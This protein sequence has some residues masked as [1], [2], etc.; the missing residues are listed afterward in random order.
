MTEP[1]AFL[2]LPLHLTDGAIIPGFR[3][4]NRMLIRAE[5]VVSW[6]YA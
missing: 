1:L 4:S 2:P 5:Q 3:D 6:E